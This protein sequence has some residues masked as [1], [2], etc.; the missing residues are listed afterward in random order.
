M[1]INR[2]FF[3]DQTRLQLFGGSFKTPQVD[4]LTAIL[5]KWEKESAEDDDRWLAYMLGTAHHETGATMQ[6]VR[7]TFASS[8]AQAIKRL[9]AAFGKGKLTWVKTPYWVP[10]SEGKSWLGRGFVQITH[11]ENY[12]K[13]GKA[14]KDDLL[15]DPTRAMDRDVALKIMFVGMRAGLFTGVSLGDRFSKTKERWLEARQI[16]NGMERAALVASYA[17]AYYGCISYTTGP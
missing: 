11:K 12:E 8:D 9:N 17:K 14:I 6:P 15:S 4:G 13:L 10:D 3:F 1:P 7:E 16:I 2:Q 5:D